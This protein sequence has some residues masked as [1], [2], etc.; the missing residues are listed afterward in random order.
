MTAQWTESRLWSLSKKSKTPTNVGEEKKG[1]GVEGR[2]DAGGGG[3]RQV[4][5]RG[6]N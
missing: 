4:L 6:L 2:E 3:F 1:C 5:T